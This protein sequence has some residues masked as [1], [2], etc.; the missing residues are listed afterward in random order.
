MLAI[1]PGL[2]RDPRGP[3]SSFDPDE[4]GVPKRVQKGGSFLCTDEYCGRYLPG[5]RGKGEPS[6]GANHVGFR[7]ARSAAR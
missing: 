3:A 1:S 2:A 5:T 6:T 7:L 4:P